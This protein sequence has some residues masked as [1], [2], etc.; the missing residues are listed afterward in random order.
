MA[1][2]VDAPVWKWRGRQ[3]C[4]L[5]ADSLDELHAF[6]GELGLREEWFQKKARF[7]HYDI[8]ESVRKKA[9]EM[10]AIEANNRTIVTK[11]LALREEYKN[12]MM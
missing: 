3:W 8:T 6:A 4:H 1:I 9:L 2:Y 11:A 10:G 5:L 12:A 7:P